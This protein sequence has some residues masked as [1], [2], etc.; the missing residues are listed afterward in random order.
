MQN[1]HFV[2]I[3]VCGCAA[4][5]LAVFDG[6]QVGVSGQLK[7]AALRDEGPGT[8]S[9]DAD[10]AY[11]CPMHPDQTAE[12]PGKCPRCGMALVLASPFDTRD[13]RLDVDTV[14]A[15]VKSGEPF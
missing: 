13:Y 3:V 9:L 4:A 11:V 1:G 15:V 7:F 8:A 10:T 14:P 6:G 2:R 12:A 5:M